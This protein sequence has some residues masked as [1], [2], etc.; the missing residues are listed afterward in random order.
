V[1]SPGGSVQGSAR[2]LAIVSNESGA[3]NRMNHRQCESSVWF[4]ALDSRQDDSENCD[5]SHKTPGFWLTALFTQWIISGEPSPL[6]GID[7]TLMFCASTQFCGIVRSLR[8]KEHDHA[9]DNSLR[10]GI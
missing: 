9:G 4:N 6:C 2:T 3:E 5:D 7:T 1:P 10:P 8:E